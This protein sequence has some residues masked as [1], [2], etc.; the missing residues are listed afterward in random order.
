MRIS[1]W[2]SDVCSSDLGMADG[3]AYMTSTGGEP[4]PQGLDPNTIKI[5][6]SVPI[7]ALED[8]ILAWELNGQALPLAHG[9]PLRMIVPGYTGVNSIKYI[10]HLAFT[11]EKSQIGRETWRERGC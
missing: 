1:D 8:A 11:K 2:S 4:I 5:E 10:K 7:S 3:M 9:G 6:R